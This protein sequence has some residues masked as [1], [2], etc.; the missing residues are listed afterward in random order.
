MNME[1]VVGQPLSQ[2]SPQQRKLNWK[3]ASSSGKYKQKTRQLILWTGSSP[4]VSGTGPARLEKCE[5]KD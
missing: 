1:N 2:T 3:G 4:N 5:R